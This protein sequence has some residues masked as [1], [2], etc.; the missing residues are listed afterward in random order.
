MEGGD[1]RKHDEPGRES[2]AGESVTRKGSLADGREG[3]V[4]DELN[5]LKAASDDS[6]GS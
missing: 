2:H 1:G 4:G 5:G 3:S 6:G